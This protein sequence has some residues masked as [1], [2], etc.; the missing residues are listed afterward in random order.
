MTAKVIENF[1]KE[2]DKEST[3][4]GYASALYSY[5]SVIYNYARTSKRVSSEDKENFEMLAERYLSEDR[6]YKQDMID[7]SKKCGKPTKTIKMYTSVVV[8]FLRTNG[9]KKIQFDYSEAKEIRRKTPKRYEVSKDKE[10]TIE[11]IRTLMQHSDIRIQ[12]LISVLLSSGMRLSEALS[13]Q[14]EDFEIIEDG[15]GKLK[16]TWMYSKTGREIYTLITPECVNTIN[17][18]LKVRSKYISE[19]CINASLKTDD[20]RLFPFSKNV[21]EVSFHNVLKCAGFKPQNG[22]KYPYHYH[23]FRGF[24]KSNMNLVMHHEIVLY[25]IGGHS[26]DIGTIYRKYTFRQVLD[27]YKASCD[28]ITIG[29]D[30]ILKK[31]Y[32]QSIKEIDKMKQNQNMNNDQMAVIIQQLGL[33]QAQMKIMEAKQAE[34][35]KELEEWRSSLL[36]YVPTGEK[37]EFE[38]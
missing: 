19:K 4:Y 21:S 10:L 2:Y 7:Y 14:S 30:P 25:L 6:D 22:D 23:Q 18:W 17:E 5:F 16:L 24:F 28:V 34:M 36:R 15:F 29:T 37:V 13:I 1:L 35:E 38:N 31:Q 9:I 32:T 27:A 26:R 33:Y 12:A 20:N 3:R 8:E 11:I